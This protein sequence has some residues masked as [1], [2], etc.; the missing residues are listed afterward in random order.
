MTKSN[1]NSKNIKKVEELANMI[2]SSNSIVFVDYT[3]LSVKVQQELKKHLKEV[4]GKMVVAKNTL[5][6]I[7][8]QKA[9]LP[10][11]AL[12]GSLLSGQ[13]AVIFAQDDPI[14]PIQTIGKFAKENELPNF[15]SAIVEGIFQ[16][17]EAL[18]RISALPSKEVLLQNSIGAVA[19]PLYSFIGT[20][21][22]NMQKLIFILDQKSKEQN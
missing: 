5:L 7:A 22:A 11:E 13:T 3:G 8:G 4:G 19:A 12:D 17:K 9:S 1:P 21:Q 20:L 2:K 6:K 15:K 16:D 18:K 10:K 14:S